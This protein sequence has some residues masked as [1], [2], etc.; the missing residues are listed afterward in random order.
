MYSYRHCF[1]EQI[2]FYEKILKMLNR[3]FFEPPGGTIATF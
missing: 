1:S 2:V 3:S